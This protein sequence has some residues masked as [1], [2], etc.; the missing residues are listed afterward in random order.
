MGEA[1]FDARNSVLNAN[2]WRDNHQGVPQGPQAYYYP[3][4]NFGGPVPGTHKK[5]LFWGGYERWLQN[6]AQCECVDFAHSQ[7]GNDGR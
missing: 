6:Q 3:G 7:P 1:Y 5:L 4:G 2:D